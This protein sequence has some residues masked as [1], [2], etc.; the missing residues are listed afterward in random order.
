[1]S[2]IDKCHQMAKLAGIAYLDPAEA[3][4]EYAAEGYPYIKFF[5]HEGAQCYAVWNKKD[6]VLCFRGTEPDQFSDILA[7]LNAIPDRAELDGYVHDGFQDEV[8]KIWTDIKQHVKVFAKVRTM[9]IC[10]HS[11]GGAMATI[12][13]SRM[14][15]K[16]EALFTYGSPRVGSSDF[17]K[18][19]Q[20]THYRH[21]NNND[22]VTAVPPYP[23]Y[24][25]HGVLRYI[26]RKGNIVPMTRWQRIK[27][28][29][30]GRLESLLKGNPIDGAADHAMD[31][32]IKYTKED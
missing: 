2:N 16:V 24:H 4:K 11:L 7:D 6:Y 17:V 28:K 32:Y 31:S 1:M 8:E 26:D 13:A 19:L 10:G 30:L 20:V 12:A 9:F 22:I 23:L 27:D 29:F 21:V 25:H 5:D 15:F 18:A 14:M 3:R